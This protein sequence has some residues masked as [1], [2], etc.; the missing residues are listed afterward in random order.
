MLWTTSD[1]AG[2]TLSIRVLSSPEQ[3]MQ[4]A[5][6]GMLRYYEGEWVPERDMIRN[7]YIRASVRVGDK[8]REHRL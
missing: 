5:E 3:R 8:M 1:E 7:E 4:V 2:T 6:M